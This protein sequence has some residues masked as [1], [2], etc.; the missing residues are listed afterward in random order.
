[1][2]YDVVIIGGGLSGIT[3]GCELQKRGLRTAAVTFGVS[4]HEIEY[5][6]YIR[7]GGRLF[8][9]DKVI[10]GRFEGDLLKAVFT[11]NFGE[12]PLEAQHFIIAT[13]KFLAGGL[14]ADMDSVSETTLGLDVSYGNER[15]DWYDPDFFASQHFMSFGVI[16][17]G[18]GHPYKEGIPVRN[19][20][21]IGEIVAGR[22]VTA[23]GAI[24][25]IKQ[26]ATAVAD[27]L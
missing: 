17:D 5:S 10:G 2:R 22:D 13:G 21:A 15:T 11:S 18:E 6:S 24:S 9:G 27:K 25:D 1:M 7:Q 3:A 19:L 20:F 12:I 14:S 8:M 4:L 23:P 16:V 26:E